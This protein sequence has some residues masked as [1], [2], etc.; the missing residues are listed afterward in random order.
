MNTLVPHVEL[1]VKAAEICGAPSF[2]DTEKDLHLHLNCSG[3]SCFVVAN[4]LGDD[5]NTYNFLI[6]QGA[7]MPDGSGSY[8][9]M[10]A[11]VSLTDK[12]N[13]QYLHK[14]QVFQFRDCVNATDH[15]EMKTPVTALYGTLAKMTVTGELPD[16]RGRIEASLENKGP[17]LNNCSTGLFPCLN[18]LV[19]YNYYGLPYLKTKG[20]IILDRKTVDFTGDAWLDR[21]WSSGSMPAVMVENK[22]QTKWMD[23]NLSNGYKVSLWDIIAHEGTENSW[24]AILS[25][26]GVYIVAPMT[27]LAKYETD[28]WQSEET[29]SFYPTKYVVEMPGINTKINVQVYEGIPQQEAVSAT[30]YHRY[31]AHSTCEGIFMGEKVSGFCCVEYVGNHKKASAEPEEI[32]AGGKLDASVNGT[33]KV[34][35]HSPMGDQELIFNYLGELAITGERQ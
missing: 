8:N 17:A 19:T 28:F 33:Y 26:D 9:V 30:G 31:E 3:D 12:A 34:I 22:F 5:G 16:G 10:V 7:L 15:L 32:P 6:H 24:A 23:L 1:A 4:V 18:N 21:Q 29:G 2:N 27:P 20:T 35:M 11:M 25:P 13:L 14:E